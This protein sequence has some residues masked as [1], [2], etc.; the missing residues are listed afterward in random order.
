MSVLVVTPSVVVS[1]VDVVELDCTSVKVND[2]VSVVVVI[3]VPAPDAS[4]PVVVTI[5]TDVDTPLNVD[6]ASITIGVLVVSS[7]LPV[8]VSVLTTVLVTC[9]PDIV[10]SV[11]TPETVCFVVVDVDNPPEYST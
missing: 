5:P 10:A 1:D 6:A 4:A 7:E 3:V 11:P 8:V 2:V 9:D